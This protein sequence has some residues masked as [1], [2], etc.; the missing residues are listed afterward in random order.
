VRVASP[1][2]T[3][4]SCE[5]A[6]AKA[7]HGSASGAL[8]QVYTPPSDITDIALQEGEQP[9]DNGIGWQRADHLD[10]VGEIPGDLRIAGCVVGVAAATSPKARLV[11]TMTEA[12][13]AL[14]LFEI[15]AYVLR[16]NLRR[17]IRPLALVA[18]RRVSPAP[19]LCR[20]SEE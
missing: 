5:S 10:E 7:R 11:V 15:R 9:V 19:G 2:I 1:S 18:W 16:D 14:P 13:E 3:G 20:P 4:Q 12:H 6:N 8:Y 17:A